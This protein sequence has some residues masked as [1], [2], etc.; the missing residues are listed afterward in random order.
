MKSLRKISYAK[1]NYGDS[2][3]YEPHSIQDSQK[4]FLI[5][6]YFAFFQL[7]QKLQGDPPVGCA[8]DLLSICLSNQPLYADRK[9]RENLNN[10]EF[11]DTFWHCPGQFGAAL[12]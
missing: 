8:T 3:A 12:F 6:L 9:I 7:S 10:E 1:I 11:S 5:L 4:I 2:P